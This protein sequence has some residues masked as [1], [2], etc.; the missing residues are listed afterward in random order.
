MRKSTPA[1]EIPPQLEL[2]CLKVLWRTGEGTVKDV[3]QVLKQSRDLAY[4]TVMTVLDRLEKRGAVER[5]KVGRSFLYRP[6]VEKAEIQRLAVK[7]LVDSLF[8]GSEEE[9]RSFLN[10]NQRNTWSAVR[11]HEVEAT[12]SEPID[13]ELL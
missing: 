4:T 12:E 13:T 5:Q 3:L 6:L 11:H 1:R 8:D 9:L 2:E 7:E 10:Y